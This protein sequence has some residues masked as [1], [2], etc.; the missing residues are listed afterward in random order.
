[1]IQTKPKKCK[2]HGP[3]KDFE[4]CGKLV[5]SRR[6]GLGVQCGCF[7]KW[8]A[9]TKE[10]QEYLVRQIIPKAKKVVKKKNQEDFEK[11]KNKATDWKK[12]LQI[13]INK[14]VRLIDKGQPCLARPYLKQFQVHAGH[15]FSRGSS[16]NIR[17]HLDNIHRQSAQ[18]NKWQNDDALLR[19]GI[20]R[21]YGQEYFDHIKALRKIPQIKYSNEQYRI[22]TIKAREIANRLK[23]TD[24]IYSKEER[25]QLRE[26]INKELGIY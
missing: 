9:T 20:I 25:L 23:K 4:G 18:S 21:E 1:M 16:S 8:V 17:Y 19:E 2:G 14:I 13:E 22:F 12:K 15:I 11:L 3:A 24:K 26:N 5:Q 7:K 6:Y 10:G